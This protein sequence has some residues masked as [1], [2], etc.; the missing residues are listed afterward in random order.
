M[1]IC[2]YLL[3]PLFLDHYDAKEASISPEIS[4]T[5]HYDIDDSALKLGLFLKVIYIIYSITQY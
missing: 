5:F 2:L 4:N 3:F 1:I